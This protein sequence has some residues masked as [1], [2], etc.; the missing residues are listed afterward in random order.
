[1]LKRKRDYTESLS[2]QFHRSLGTFSDP[3]S[4]LRS[5]TYTDISTTG[6]MR[7]STAIF[8]IHAY[9]FCVRSLLG[10]GLVLVHIG[11]VSHTL[12]KRDVCRVGVL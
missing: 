1:M 7:R 8:S 10:V 11:E 5:G 6:R 3:G 4:S 12:E 9:L 2:S